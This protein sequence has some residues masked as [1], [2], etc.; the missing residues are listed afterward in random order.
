MVK[1]VKGSQSQE[2]GSLRITLNFPPEQSKKLREQAGTFYIPVTQYIKSIVLK[3]L[4][5]Q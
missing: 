5:Q 3:H 4:D 2:A 1:K